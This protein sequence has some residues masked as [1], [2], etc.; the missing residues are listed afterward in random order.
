A[1]N[2]SGRFYGHISGSGQLIVAPYTVLELAGQ[3]GQLSDFMGDV[4]LGGNGTSGGTLIFDN[5]NGNAEQLRGHVTGYAGT[6]IVENGGA[7]ESITVGGSATFEGVFAVYQ[8]NYETDLVA[9]MP[10]ALF[11][12]GNDFGSGSLRLAVAEA[13]NY[14]STGN[15]T[16]GD[17]FA[18]TISVQS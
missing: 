11:D 5:H 4:R 12:N 16:I 13:A 1:Y 7:I 6:A 10:T 2:G 9:R 15:V 8:N 18:G 14:S 3:S 17:A